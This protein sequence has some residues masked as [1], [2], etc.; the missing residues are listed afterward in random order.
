[1]LSEVMPVPLL[2]YLVSQKPNVRGAHQDMKLTG[3]CVK[4]SGLRKLLRQISFEKERLL[5]PWNRKIDAR[6]IE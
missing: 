3:H 4:Q 2:G 1:M 5:R 6:S